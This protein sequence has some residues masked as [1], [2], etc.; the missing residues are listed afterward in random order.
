M[1]VLVVGGGIAGLVAARSLAGRGYRVAL[2]E[3]SDRL[4]GSVRSDVLGDVAMDVGAESVAT[5][6]AGALQLIAELG[7]DTAPPRRGGAWLQLGDRA[8]PLPAAGVL[9][10]PSV[11]L[12]DDVRA[13]IGWSGA[14]RAYLDT[15]RPELRVGTRETL[16]SLVR[17]RMGAQVLDTLV[18][19]VVEGVYGVDPDDIEADALAPGLTAAL[20]RAGSLAGAVATLR[21]S[22]PAGAAVTGIAGGVHLLA[23]ALADDVAERGVAVVT[24]ARVQHL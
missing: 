14:L 2:V 3:G 22:A 23:S 10:I 17:R 21:G 20:A 8:V 1:T 13:A 6:G 11:A 5:K 24:G 18:R 12:A 16:G 4:G 15:V 9:G 19:P 7:L